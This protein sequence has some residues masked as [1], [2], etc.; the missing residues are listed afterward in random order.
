MAAPWSR[1]NECSVGMHGMHGLYAADL[2]PAFVPAI[3]KAA[4]IL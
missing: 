4:H 3:R 2:S 1:A